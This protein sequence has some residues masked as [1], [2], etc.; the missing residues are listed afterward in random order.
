MFAQDFQHYV[1]ITCHVFT[2]QPKPLQ[3]SM[4]GIG[5]CNYRGC[6]YQRIASH[7]SAT[8]GAL[9][10]R[11][12]NLDYFCHQCFEHRIFHQFNDVVR[13]GHMGA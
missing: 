13:A 10:R 8:A 3:A 9:L 12:D 2:R 6:K 7:I 11:C 1:C 5:L 4:M